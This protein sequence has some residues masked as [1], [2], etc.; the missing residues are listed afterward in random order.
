MEKSKLR[1]TPESLKREL[2]EIIKEY[3]LERYD[4]KIVDDISGYEL[5]NCINQDNSFYNLCNYDICEWTT[6]QSGH[7]TMYNQATIYYDL[8]GIKR[9]ITID[10]D[11]LSTEGE[12]TMTIDEATDILVKLEIE[13]RAEIDRLDAIF[14]SVPPKPNPYVN[15]NQKASL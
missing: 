5:I 1:L 14:K 6:E 15:S 9:I 4:G 7:E 3:N 10:H 11:P 8:G 2:T 12:T 13:A